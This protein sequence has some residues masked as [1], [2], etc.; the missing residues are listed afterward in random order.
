LIG[1]PP[2]PPPASYSLT[3]TVTDSASPTNQTASQAITISVSPQPIQGVTITQNNSGAAPNQTNLL[4]RFTQAAAVNYTGTLSLSFKPD[5]SVTN[6]PATYVDPAGGFPASSQNT[7]SLTQNFSVNT[8]QSQA[9]TQFAQGTV[10]G[11]W[12]VTLTS[13]NPG[14]VPSPTPSYTVQ[15]APGAP[16]ITTGSVKIVF[17]ATNTGFT[18][19]L[20]G[21]ATTRDISSAG[22]TFAPAG[23]GQLTGASVTVPFNGQDQSQ[24]FNT[25]PGRSAGGT[26][27][28]AV[29]F[30]YSGDPDAL[31]SVSVTL[32]N[33][34][35]Q[36]SIPVIGT[37]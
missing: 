31:G 14:G 1:T 6:V 16:A 18:V 26:F 34:R 33:G 20:S 7:T 24:W 3:V 36:M 4:V 2:N 28:L 22:F 5:A 15:V 10:A 11:T 30:T 8:G 35:G 12:T 13:L 17:N 23:S 9:T 37:K 27:S 29:P 19:Q 21:Y 32:T 25:N